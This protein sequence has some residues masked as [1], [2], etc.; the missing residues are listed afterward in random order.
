M[1]DKNSLIRVILPRGIKYFD[2]KLSMHLDC[3]TTLSL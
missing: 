3:Q 2:V 1:R